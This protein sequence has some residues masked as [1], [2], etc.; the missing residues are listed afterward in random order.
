[1]QSGFDIWVREV[2][3]RLAFRGVKFEAGVRGSLFCGRLKRRAPSSW[4]VH[5][6]L[7]L[8][9]GLQSPGRTTPVDWRIR[10][11]RPSVAAAAQAA[12]RTVPISNV[13]E[14]CPRVP[15]FLFAMEK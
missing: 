11:E 3:G 6:W 15:L 5:L 13:M 14:L 1:V 12:G 7:S 8:P 2:V 10:G 9:H 4:L